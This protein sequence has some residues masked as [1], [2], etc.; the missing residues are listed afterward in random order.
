[1][2]GRVVL[3]AST[4][5]LRGTVTCPGTDSVI[6]VHQA[7]AKLYGGGRDAAGIPLPMYAVTEPPEILTAAAGRSCEA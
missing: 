5:H 6:M 2:K 1:M 3:K 7:M 4:T